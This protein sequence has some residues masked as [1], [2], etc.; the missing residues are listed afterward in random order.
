MSDWSPLVFMAEPLSPDTLSARL[1]PLRR[2]AGLRRLVA[3]PQLA[4]LEPVLLQPEWP[5]LRQSRLAQVSP[6]AEWKSTTP[7]LGAM[8]TLVPVL[9]ISCA[10]KG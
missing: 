4:W 1:E 7:P 3:W 5:L 9:G 8:N 2:L 10:P 6:S